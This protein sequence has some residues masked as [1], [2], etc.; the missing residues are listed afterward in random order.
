MHSPFRSEREA[1]MLVVAIG[2]G[3]AVVIAV[4][5][6][7]APVVGAILAALLIGAGV[8]HALRQS[9]GSL[10]HDV[11][12][13]DTGPDTHRI[14]VVANRTVEGA[15]LLAEITNRCR[16]RARVELLVVSPALSVS[17]LEHLASATDRARDEA[18]GRLE[19]SITA[20]ERAGFRA[21][22]EIGDEDPFIAI[23]D[24][25][26]EFGADELIISTLPPARSRW[27]E[28][29]LVAQARAELDLPISHVVVGTTDRERSAAP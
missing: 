22:G 21:R 19:R 15:E 17:R 20:L 6:L 16:G 12:V 18:T 2:A 10:P 4:A 9:R 25:L 23:E 24:A 28:R 7:I 27:L 26:R 13:A 1:F 29:G 8:G 14:L 11:Q 5:L 3:A